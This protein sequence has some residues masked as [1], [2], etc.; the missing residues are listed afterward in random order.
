[1]IQYL[2]LTALVTWCRIEPWVASDVGFSLSAVYNYAMNRRFT[3]ASRQSH[4]VAASRFALLVA[5]GVTT[6]TVIMK[7]LT[8]IGLYYLIS[9]VVASAVVLILNFS[10]A[11]YWVFAGHKSERL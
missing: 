11:N 1:M 10:L 8:Q 2:V 6:N 7:G 9:Q 5:A 3:F 4:L